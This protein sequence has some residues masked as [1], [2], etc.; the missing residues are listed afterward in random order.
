MSLVLGVI[1]VLV[2]CYVGIIFSGKFCSWRE[3]IFV[4]FAIPVELGWVFFL[5]LIKD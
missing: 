2:R 1:V 3:R 4:D 5:K